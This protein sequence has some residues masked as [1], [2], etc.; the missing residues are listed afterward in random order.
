MFKAE[1]SFYVLMFIPEVRNAFVCIIISAGLGIS[2]VPCEVANNVMKYE[3][4]LAS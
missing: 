1:S 4:V 2:E 3:F